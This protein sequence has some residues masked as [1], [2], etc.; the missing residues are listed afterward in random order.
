MNKN[1]YPWENEF[2]ELYDRSL[3]RIKTGTRDCDTLFD[4]KDRAFLASIGSKP[5]EMFDS[6]DDFSRYGE[7]S[8]EDVLEVQRMRFDYFSRTEQG[9]P[10]A[11]SLAGL[12]PKQAEL[13]GISWLP[14]A[15]DKVRAKIAGILPDDYYYPCA[16]DR[17]FLKEIGFSVP[18]FFRLVRDSKSDEEVLESVRAGMKSGAHK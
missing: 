13:G 4:D 8:Y 7:P 17:A 15:I 9:G 11:S 18:D 1:S 14:R 6:V 10:P 3:K 16:G 2:K 5:V 12:R